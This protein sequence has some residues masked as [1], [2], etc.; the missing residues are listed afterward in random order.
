MDMCMVNFIAN[1]SG[2]GFSHC[3]KK[4]PRD[5]YSVRPEAVLYLIAFGSGSLKD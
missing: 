4:G 1:Q 2:K 3:T 5:R